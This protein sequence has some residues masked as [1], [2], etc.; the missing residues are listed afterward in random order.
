MSVAAIKP[1]SNIRAIT[2][3]LS[4]LSTYS[5]GIWAVEACCV[6]SAKASRMTY[7]PVEWPSMCMFM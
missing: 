1:S 7:A 6:A 2:S 4:S 3:R 5:V